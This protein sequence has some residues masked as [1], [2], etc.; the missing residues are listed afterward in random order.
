[1]YSYKV[2]NN[3][4]DAASYNVAAT[5]TN[6]TISSA[7]ACTA[8]TTT[9]NCG[10]FSLVSGANASFNIIVTAPGAGPVTASGTVTPTNATD[11]TSA[12][13]SASQSTTVTPQADLQITKSG[14]ASSSAGSNIIY[15]IA[16]KNNGPSDAANVVVSDTPGAG[17]TFVG[18]SG[19]CSSAF[20]CSIGTLT[21]GTTATILATYSTSPSST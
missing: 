6:G 9:A 15:T 4:P 16:V 12:N 8:T 7:P 17:L 19:A 18:N 11:Q 21:S 5:I 2:T 14:P 3:G 20:P 10:A 1:T 13:D